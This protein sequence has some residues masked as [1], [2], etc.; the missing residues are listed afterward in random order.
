M[1]IDSGM[2]IR[3]TP[4]PPLPSPSIPTNK[5]TAYLCMYEGRKFVRYYGPGVDDIF[6]VS[7]F[8]VKHSKFRAFDVYVGRGF[9]C[10]SGVSYL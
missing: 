7:K 8:I 4:L 5:H 9:V 10:V 2:P 6:E 3:G 1:T